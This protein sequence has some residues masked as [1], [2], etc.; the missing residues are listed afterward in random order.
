MV[1]PKTPF[2]F[3]WAAHVSVF[4]ISVLPYHEDSLC[5]LGTSCQDPGTVFGTYR[6]ASGDMSDNRTISLSNLKSG[7]KIYYDC[8]NPGY[9]L[10]SGGTP[11]EYISCDGST[12]SPNVS[13]FECIGRPQVLFISFF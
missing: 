5:I 13:T 12:F 3:Y 8:I 9:T 10:S 7:G 1:K 2:R 4:F 11:V 6:S